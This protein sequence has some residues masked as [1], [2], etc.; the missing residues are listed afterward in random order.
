MVTAGCQ[1]RDPGGQ[2]RVQLD[3][4]P[5]PA[6]GVQQPHHTEGATGEAD[7]ESRLNLEIFL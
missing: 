2:A 5:A 3:A 1:V 6:R 4:D 7:C